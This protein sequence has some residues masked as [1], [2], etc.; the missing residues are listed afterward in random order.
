MSWIL[1]LWIVSSIFAALAGVCDGIECEFCKKEFTSLGRHRWRC[2][3]RV[4]TDSIDLDQRQVINSYHS[5]RPFE[6]N[7]DFIGENAS[8]ANTKNMVNRNNEESENTLQEHND[9]HRFT[10]YCGKKC[11]AAITRCD[12]SPRFFCIDNFL[13]VIFMIF[14]IMK[15]MMY[16]ICLNYFWSGL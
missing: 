2:K 4:N 7:H 9:P 3:A 5:T 6:N 11:K 16:R 14:F 12:L 10:C 1:K 13:K 15:T 8:I